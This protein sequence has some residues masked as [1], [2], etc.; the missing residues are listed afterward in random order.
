[1]DAPPLDRILVVEDSES[2]ARRF[3]EALAGH[4]RV[5]ERTGSLD[6]GWRLLQERR[7]Q[8]VLVDVVLPDGT[9]IEL[10][11][12]S[13]TAPV[14]PTFVAVS[15]AAD[16]DATF[17]L[18]ELGVRGFLRKPVTLEAL[19][20]AIERAISA[21]PDLLPHLRASVG[22]RAVR[23]VEQEVRRVMVHEALARARGSRRGAAR[24]LSV[25]RQLLQ[26]IL[27][28]FESGPS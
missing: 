26:H 20:I 3:Q 1:M 5:V 23:Q 28:A 11:E 13:L 9:A 4:A 12:R 15:G 6:E 21:P 14:V 18:A 22:H 7:P 8:L 10:V 27:S 17:R 19:H 24:L 16:P 25:S 2:L